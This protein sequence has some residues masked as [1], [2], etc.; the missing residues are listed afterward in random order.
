MK[1]WFHKY[2]LNITCY[3]MLYLHPSRRAIRGIEVLH[4][5]P[6][7]KTLNCGDAMVSVA[8]SCHSTRLVATPLFNSP[9][10]KN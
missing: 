5:D 1:S 3:C 2:L 6:T 4:E 8:K 9:P 10:G 7:S